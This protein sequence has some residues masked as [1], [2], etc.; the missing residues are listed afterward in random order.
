MNNKDLQQA[1]LFELLCD[2][3]MFE[4]TGQ[5]SEELRQLREEF[6]HFGNDISF[7]KAAA[8]ISLSNLD[9]QETL[10][11]N[12]KAR[13]LQSAD[14]YF[15]TMVADVKTDHQ[16]IPVGVTSSIE[17]LEPVRSSLMNW[18]GWGVAAL[19]CIALIA[20][21]WLT[22]STPENNVVD[23]PKKVATPTPEPSLN[24]K[25]QQLLASAS[26][27]V[28]RDLTS[29]DKNEDLTGEFVWSN[30]KQEGYATFRGLPRLDADSE[31]Y[32]LWI[33]DEAQGEKTPINAGVF[34]INETGEITVP[35]DADLRVK[36]P[37]MF[38]VTV[39]KPGGVV[40]SKR[41]KIVALAKL[42]A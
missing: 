9:I 24:E 35:V 33:F 28:K 26:D 31:T 41:E 23:V 2:E 3:V 10:P 5:D 14:R 37:I 19:A 34:N 15:E 36:K 29:P 38:A 39:E 40:V 22:R 6:P 11:H 18:L 17:P 4:L 32:Q 21:V 16:T 12:L 30:D 8:V 7:E 13:I 42:E 25:K 20:N 1:R 27:V